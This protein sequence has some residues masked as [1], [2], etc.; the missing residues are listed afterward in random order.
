MN[1]HELGR[2]L[3]MLEDSA[4]QLSDRIRRL[5]RIEEHR[6]RLIRQLEEQ[7]HTVEHLLRQILRQQGKETAPVPGTLTVTFH[8]NGASMNA[9][10]VATLPTTRKDQTALAPTDI[11]SITFQKTS[12]G[13]DG[14]T[15]GPQ[16]S[17]QVNNAVAGAGLA[18]TDTTFTDPNSLAGDAYTFFVSDTAGDAGAVSNIVSNPG[19]GGTGVGGKPSA[20]AAGTLAGTFN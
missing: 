11:A 2:R 12:L 17:L 9:V 7:I 1:E 4:L 10:L 8:P 19:T 3:A 20:P 13:A 5:E 6:H 16:V 15:P 18:L 14:V